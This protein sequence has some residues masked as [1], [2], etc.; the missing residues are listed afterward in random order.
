MKPAVQSTVPSVTTATTAVQPATPTQTGTPPSNAGLGDHFLSCVGRTGA[1]ASIV[2]PVDVVAN[3]GGLTLAA[4]DEIAVFTPDDSLCVGVVIW[5]GQNVAITAWGD[6]SQTDAL[7]GLR[8]GEQMRFKIWRKATAQESIVQDVLFSLG[9][10]IYATD[11]LH[12]VVA[13][14]VETN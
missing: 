2:V 5:T 4:G 11:S 12:A 7:D 1:N 8:E 3:N 10:G 14:T 6:D 13:L 9:D